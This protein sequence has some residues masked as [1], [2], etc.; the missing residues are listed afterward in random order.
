MYLSTPLTAVCLLE[1]SLRCKSHAFLQLRTW[2]TLQCRSRSKEEIISRQQWDSL[3]VSVL[4]S[5]ISVKA[6]VIAQGPTGLE[7]LVVR[8][9]DLSPLQN[10]S[11]FGKKRERGRDDCSICEAG[12]CLFIQ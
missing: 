5:L 6:A 12:D 2:Q 7:G 3:R 9:A 11:N 4:E 10:A 8:A 1:A